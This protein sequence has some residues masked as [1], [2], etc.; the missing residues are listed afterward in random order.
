M[1]RLLAVSVLVFSLNFIGYANAENPF[2]HAAIPVSPGTN[3]FDFVAPDSGTTNAAN[4]F[5]R[6]LV[7]VSPR[8]N[9][10]GFVAPKSG[11][12][13]TFVIENVGRSRLIGKAT[14]KPPFKI[15]SGGTYSLGPH[16]SQLITIA[17]Q[18]IG[19]SNDIQVVTF[20][21]GGNA[22][23]IVSGTSDKNSARKAGR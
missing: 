15:I 13:N 8:T 1:K 20:T 5:D 21:G 7:L 18:P 4:L 9:N 19:A 17:Y 2:D 10:F 3:D 6:A 16:G 23:A 14:V 12:T 11:A 22:T